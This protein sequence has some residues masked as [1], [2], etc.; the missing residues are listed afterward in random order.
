MCQVCKV[1][2]EDNDKHDQAVQTNIIW[3]LEYEG[4]KYLKLSKWFNFNIFNLFE[5]CLTC[6]L[7]FSPALA[8]KIENVTWIMQ[9]QYRIWNAIYWHSKCFISIEEAERPKI[10][11]TFV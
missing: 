6:T 9:Q 3:F 8:L 7:D 5:N 10:Y 1:A 2:Y 11:T 4:K